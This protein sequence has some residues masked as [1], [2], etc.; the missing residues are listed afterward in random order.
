MMYL[1]KILSYI[2]ISI[3]LFWGSALFSQGVPTQKKPVDKKVEEEKMDRVEFIR[4]GVDPFSV[5][6][7]FIY[8]ATVSGVTFQLDTEIKEKYFPVLEIGNENF[9]MD[10][11]NYNMESTGFFIR[12]GVDQ[13]FLS[14]LNPEDQDIFFAGLR[15]CI[16]S[17]TAGVSDIVLPNSLGNEAINIENETYFTQWG[18][19]TAG[20][21]TK[22]VSNFFLGWTVRVKRRFSFSK[23]EMNPYYVSG[24][25]VQD[26]SLNVEM[27][28]QVLYALPYKFRRK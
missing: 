19:L 3:S 24:Y 7:S 16:G 25:G 13:N 8:P 6:K 9:S 1:Q 27:S 2:I 18:E 22:L 15:Y 21:K 17:G 23:M 11:S 10:Y 14:Y 26:K 12:L 5:V 28:V 20:V 4:L